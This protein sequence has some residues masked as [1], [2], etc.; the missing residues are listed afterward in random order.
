[1]FKLAEYYFNQA[2]QNKEYYR[3]A[4]KY[5]M[6]VGKLGD[7]VGYTNAAISLSNLAKKESAYKLISNS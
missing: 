2:N 4:H 1:M 7:H 5:F 6:I 3:L